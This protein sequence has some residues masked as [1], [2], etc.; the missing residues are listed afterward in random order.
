MSDSA[1]LGEDEDSL[2]H[3][4]P[5]PVEGSAAATTSLEA[6]KDARSLMDGRRS[7]G[8]VLMEMLSLSWRENEALEA[9]KAV[10]L[11]RAHNDPDSAALRQ[12]LG[13][14]TRKKGL[15]AQMREKEA[16][17]AVL[18]ALHERG[19]FFYDTKKQDRS[20]TL[21]FDKRL[22][23]LRGMSGDAFQSWFAR[24]TGLNRTEKEF[25]FVLA[26][27]EDEALQGNTTGTTPEL[28]WASRG[29]ALYISNGEGQMVRIS[30][31]SV[32]IVDNGT[33]GVL[34]QSGSTLAPW[35]LTTPRDIF[36]K[37]AVFRDASYADAHGNDLVRLFVIALPATTECKPHLVLTGGIRSGKTLLSRAVAKLLG[38]PPRTLQP[39]E[40]E[41]GKRDFWI[42][43][44]AGG[45]LCLD[46][47]D[48]KVPWLAQALGS[49]STSGGI[50]RKMN[51]TDT[52]I[53]PLTCRASLIITSANPHFGRDGAL[54]DR[55]LVVRMITR[56]V[57]AS[58]SELLA[59]V[60]ANRDAGLSHI[61]STLSK[62]LADG[63]PTE[64][65]N[66]RHPDFGK[67]AVRIGRA[68]GMEE[69]A[70]AALQ[71]A[72]SDKSRFC[73]ENDE[74]AAA[75]L[76]LVQGKGGFEGGALDLLEALRE[77]DADSFPAN[78][79]SAKSVGRRL[80]N[81]WPHITEV[82]DAEMHTRQG[83][84]HYLIKGFKGFR[85]AVSA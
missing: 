42:S 8:D 56:S 73:L 68:L 12:H 15:S 54:A 74:L 44:N 21:Y 82:L 67:L 53:V 85:R 75:L 25:R 84:K 60:E 4:S 76:N 16:A 66:K 72:E 34:F 58:E 59:D 28:Y 51:Y 50:E 23:I 55:L 36:E 13:E 77:M 63:A 9:M 35:Q 33:D 27:V 30:S 46:N 65:V 22:K 71:S 48:T 1:N 61:A 26:A 83:T 41:N 62:A 78:F 5:P 37:C 52:G 17:D 6:L 32:E 2:V 45:L 64:N 79:W 14:I 29:E 31:G 11:E 19:R 39:V 43:A 47:A 57:T 38:I 24:F 7:R 20:G 40:G 49:A 69:S 81:L 3:N 70:I 18:E 80:M 10:E